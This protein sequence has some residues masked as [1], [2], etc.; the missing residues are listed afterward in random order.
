MNS[1]GV[2]ELP[3]IKINAQSNLSSNQSRQGYQNS[4]YLAQF[5]QST[6]NSYLTPYWNSKNLNKYNNSQEESLSHRQYSNQFDDQQRTV[7]NYSN[8]R[9]KSQNYSPEITQSARSSSVILNNQSQSK[10]KYYH[11]AQNYQNISNGNQD[12]HSQTF[13]PSIT[14][15]SQSFAYSKQDRQSQEGETRTYFYT[16]NQQRNKKVT[17]SHYQGFYPSD[18]LSDDKQSS[19]QTDTQFNDKINYKQ[20]SQSYRETESNLEQQKNSQDA[21]PKIESSTLYNEKKTYFPKTTEN[22]KFFLNSALKDIH[23][24]YSKNQQLEKA[25]KEKIRYRSTSKSQTIQENFFEPRKRLNSIS[26]SQKQSSQDM[27]FNQIKQQQSQPE[28]F[29]KRN[30]Q[31]V[32]KNTNY[33]DLHQ[34]NQV[35]QSTKNSQKNHIKQLSDQNNLNWHQENDTNYDVPLNYRASVDLGQMKQKTNYDFFMKE[36][37]QNHL[38][39]NFH[40]KRIDELSKPKQSTIKAYPQ[41]KAQSQVQKKRKQNPQ[42]V[43]SEKQSNI[44]QIQ[45][46]SEAQQ[47]IRIKEPKESKLNTQSNNNS[48]VKE[49]QSMLKSDGKEK[50]NN[51]NNKKQTT[52]AN[53]ETQNLVDSKAL[54]MDLLYDDNDLDSS[55]EKLQKTI[56]QQNEVQE[57][58]SQNSNNTTHCIT[59]IDKIRILTG[60][61]KFHF[62]K[63]QDHSQQ[64][65]QTQSLQQT[66]DFVK[67][68]KLA[69]IRNDKIERILSLKNT[70]SNYRNSLE[71][72]F[73]SQSLGKMEKQGEI[74]LFTSNQ[75][76]RFSQAFSKFQNSRLLN[77][78]KN[79]QSRK[80]EFT[81]NYGFKLDK[82]IEF[83]RKQKEQKELK[84]KEE[85]EQKLKQQKEILCKQN[86]ERER[87]RNLDVDIVIHSEEI[88]TKLVFGEKVSFIKIPVVSIAEEL[89][90]QYIQELDQFT[91]LCTSQKQMK[92]AYF[93][94]RKE[95][96]TELKQQHYLFHINSLMAKENDLYVKDPVAVRVD[97]EYYLLQFYK[98][99]RKL[100]DILL[101]QNSFTIQSKLYQNKSINYEEDQYSITNQENEEEEVR[102]Q[103]FLSESQIINIYKQILENITHTNEILNIFHSNL[104]LDN[105]AL[106]EG[107]GVSIINFDETQ[108]I[109]KKANQKTSNKNYIISNN[110]LQRVQYQKYVKFEEVSSQEFSPLEYQLH[111]IICLFIQLKF[112]NPELMSESQFKQCIKIINLEQPLSVSGQ[113]IKQL[114]QYQQLS[115]QNLIQS[116]ADKIYIDGHGYRMD[117]LVSYKY[118]KQEN[119]IDQI[120]FYLT[121]LQ[122]QKSYQMINCLS[123]Q[124]FSE[125]LILRAF[126]YYLTK[127]YELSQEELLQF[128][129]EYL[130]SYCKEQVQ[131]KELGVQKQVEGEKIITVNKKI[132]QNVYFWKGRIE[133]MNKQ[134]DKSDKSFEK[135][136]NISQN[137]CNSLLD[138]ADFQKQVINLNKSIFYYEQAEKYVIN[139]KDLN[140]HQIYYVQI[141]KRQIYFYQNTDNIDKQVEVAN[142]CI[143]FLT[144]TYK[145]EQD[146]ELLSFKHQFS[147]L[148][149][150]QPQTKKQ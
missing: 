84:E 127:Q 101:M 131:N 146:C 51:H 132:L 128:E 106:F 54:E 60:K 64:Q 15:S 89:D 116:Y 22:Y 115:Q 148:I 41:E 73:S 65:D 8:R 50:S 87:H 14:P 28:E 88:Q 44:A 77:I 66:K 26:S 150:Q 107:N 38:R 4:I 42:K 23:G 123:Q 36:T 125:Q 136:I 86:Y 98:V 83:Y 24:I 119:H 30:E 31:L 79:L 57:K 62:S 118:Q 93:I 18:D 13:R 67:Q 35:T 81:V 53:N 32:L 104:S 133:F 111:D 33:C 39:K 45:D 110:N 10:Y 72:S 19:E 124:Y 17:Q 16:N 5:P 56:K 140:L 48:L 143:Q 90:I 137:T 11:Q 117:Y 12:F 46:N 95:K 3:K 74:N 20:N 58:L 130:E 96:L 85:G 37:N 91:S 78:E 144:H 6:R 113:I 105:I 75:D 142:R 99:Y 121:N 145:D 102:D 139:N 141:M 97:S 109:F 55:F 47:K 149:S 49:N 103:P 61:G 7:Q 92:G 40:S 135:Y 43:Q 68:Q 94:L 76:D 59:S 100:S 29:Q 108:I 138:L 63:K 71:S 147:N 134:F 122:L 120:L 2:T 112:A 126:Y 80:V 9:K 129:K 34:L 114:I 52:Q 69:Q 21:M 25:N 70:D 82:E 27:Y 1:K